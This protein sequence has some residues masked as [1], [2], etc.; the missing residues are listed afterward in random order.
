M[1]VCM[2]VGVFE[3]IVLSMMKIPTIVI[4]AGSGLKIN[5]TIVYIMHCEIHYVNH[6][7]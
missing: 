5:K 1:Y 2:Y 7:I 3:S 4:Y 6:R